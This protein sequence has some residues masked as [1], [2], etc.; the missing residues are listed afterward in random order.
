MTEKLSDFVESQFGG[1]MQDDLEQAGGVASK[2]NTQTIAH[3]LPAAPRVYGITST[4]L[5]HIA[6]ISAVSSTT[7]T[8]LLSDAAGAAVNTPENVVWWASL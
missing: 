5:G 7:L 3:G 8:V 2:S 6:G 1:T 4:V